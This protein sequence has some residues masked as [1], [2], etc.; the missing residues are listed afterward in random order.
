MSAQTETPVTLVE[1]LHECAEWLARLAADSE[2][3]SRARTLHYDMA[4]KCEPLLGDAA[5]LIEAM[6][7]R[8][9]FAADRIAALEAELATA[10]ESDVLRLREAFR[11]G[12]TFCA[13]FNRGI[14]HVHISPHRQAV[15]QGQERLYPL[16]G[17]S[18]A[19]AP[20]MTPNDDAIEPMSDLASHFLAAWHLAIDVSKRDGVREGKVVCPRCQGTVRFSRPGRRWYL[21]CATAGCI[22]GSGH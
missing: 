19:G 1:R 8:A 9:A 2:G 7:I 13:E 21:K 5:G 14:G 3:M 17:V 10:K 11:A 22:D 12:L 18:D 6:D 15:D 4:A 16:L 20:P